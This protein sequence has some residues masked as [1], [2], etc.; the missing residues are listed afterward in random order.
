MQYS[1]GIQRNYRKKV[2]ENQEALTCPKLACSLRRD[3]PLQCPLSYEG[4]PQL[5]VTITNALDQNVWLQITNDTYMVHNVCRKPPSFDSPFRSAALP[6]GSSWFVRP[7]R[8]LARP[9][10]KGRRTSRRTAFSFRFGRRDIQRK[11]H[12]HTTG[13]KHGGMCLFG[14][15]VVSPVAPLRTDSVTVGG[16]CLRDGS[17]ALGTRTTFALAWALLRGRCTEA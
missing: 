3:S 2:I 16:G 5:W 1:N 11:G 13:G 8:Q 6:L 14:N 15:I 12:E 10:L 17:A 4:D 9:M 7:G